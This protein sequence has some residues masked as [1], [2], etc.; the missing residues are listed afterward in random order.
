MI[1]VYGSAR[2]Q[3]SD[4]LLPASV[5]LEA[6]PIVSFNLKGLG[7]DRVADMLDCQFGIAVR[8]GLHC[9]A[10]AHKTLGTLNQGTVRASFGWFNTEDEV[11]TLCDALAS[12]MSVRV[13]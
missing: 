7:A 11:E 8:A 6:V 10:L 13:S 3:P 5:M 1:E 4:T 9:A 2:Q 12:I